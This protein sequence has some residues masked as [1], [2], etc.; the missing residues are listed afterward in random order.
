MKVS[1]ITF[2]F[3]QMHNGYVFK[4]WFCELL[5]FINIVGQLFLIDRFLGGEF[6]TYGPRVSV[7]FMLLARKKMF[8]YCHMSDIIQMADIIFFAEVKLI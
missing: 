7:D 5:C 3:L 1:C 6:L 8:S 2:V 4:Y